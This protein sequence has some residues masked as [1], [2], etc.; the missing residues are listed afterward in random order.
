[1]SGKMHDSVVSQFRADRGRAAR[2]EIE[3]LQVLSCFCKVEN[4]LGLLTCVTQSFEGRDAGLSSGPLQLIPTAH[5]TRIGDWLARLSFR[6][7]GL[8]PQ[9]VRPEYWI[10]Q[11]RQQFARWLAVGHL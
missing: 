2:I 4:R 11:H 10:G 7:C 5:N 1:M 9:V 8:D 6:R 3:R